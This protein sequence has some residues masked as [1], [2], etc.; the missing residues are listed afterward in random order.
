[1]NQNQDT[2]HISRRRF[3]HGSLL[4]GAAVTGLPLMGKDVSDHSNEGI[5]RDGEPS[6]AKGE[7]LYNGI[8]LPDTWPPKDLQP[9]SYEPMP[10]PYLKNPPEVIPVDM[11]RQLFV[12]DFLISYTNLERR[13]HQP[14][15]YEGNPVLR[16]ETEAEMNQGFCPTAAPFSDGCFY[17]PVE[18][19]FKLYY[20]AG[21]FDGVALAISEDGIH[22]DRPEFDVVPGTNLVLDPGNLRRDGVSV[23]LDHESTDPAERFKMYFWARTGAIGTKLKRGGGYILTSKD[24]IHWGWRGETG[25]T[26]D[27]S[28][29]FYNPFRNVWA[30]TMRKFGRALP[31][32]AGPHGWNGRPR[33]RARSYWETDNLLSALNDWSGH[34]PVFWLGADRFDHRRPGYP[35]GRVPQIYKVDAVGY[36]SLMLGLIQLHYGPPNNDCAKEGVPKLTELQ[37]AFSRDGFHWDRSNRET[38][39]GATL[40][41]DSWERAYIHSIGGV[42][43]VVGDELHFYYA[44]FQGDESNLNLNAQWNGMYANASTGLATLRR[45]GFVSMGAGDKE[46]VLLT[47]PLSFSGKYLFLNLDASQGSVDVEVCREDGKALPGFTRKDCRTIQVDCTRHRVLWRGE[48]NLESV[49]SNPV[50]LKFTMTNSKLYAFWISQDNDGKSGGATA[51]GGPGFTGT[52]DV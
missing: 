8:V 45:D 12:D 51:A 48:H 21:W 32:W 23:W 26:G 49:S 2:S 6:D 4:T 28:T 34:D 25:E 35:A 52:W 16:P 14:E 15:K 7:V 47:S 31:P 44:A 33:G 1:M 36:E 20:M 17:D 41:K 46:G 5:G 3:L 38:F 40:E 24:G 19:H 13:F 42:C 30:L 9:D 37:L 11:G 43:N 18:K 10:V 29:L 50:R 27:N 22:W 39:I